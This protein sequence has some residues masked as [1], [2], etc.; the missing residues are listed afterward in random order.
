[1]ISLGERKSAFGFKAV[2]VRYLTL[3]VKAALSP[4]FTATV[5]NPLAASQARQDKTLVLVN[6]RIPWISILRILQKVKE[7]EELIPSRLPSLGLP[8]T[9]WIGAYRPNRRASNNAY[10]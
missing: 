1:M 3:N 8:R 10:M 2:K 5:A 7:I 4:C 6:H 9:R